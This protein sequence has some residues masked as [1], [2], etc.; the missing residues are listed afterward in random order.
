MEHEQIEKAR[1]R[2]RLLPRDSSAR[3]AP[4]EALL[5]DVG[6]VE[7]MVAELMNHQISDGE[8]PAPADDDVAAALVLVEQIRHQVDWL[9][10][11]V[12]QKARQRQMG[13]PQ[14]AAAQGYK[15]P[16]AATQRYQ[17]LVA[18]LTE[19]SNGLG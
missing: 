11:G 12:V 13:W 17:R 15:S 4:A 9:E 5:G 6:L 14:I 10:V 8:Q 19:L 16:Q 1:Q 3:F 2:L 18:K 7:R